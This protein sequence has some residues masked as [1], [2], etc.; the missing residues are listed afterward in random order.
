VNVPTT[1]RFDV[2]FTQSLRQ[3]TQLA[4]GTVDR[5]LERHLTD[6]GNDN[7]IHDLV[8]LYRRLACELPDDVRTSLRSAF[9]DEAPDSP[10]RAALQVILDNVELCRNESRPLCQD[11]GIPVFYCALPEQ[12][13]QTAF[14]DTI[15]EATRL[16]VIQVPLRP[17]AV[18]T[19]SGRN[20]GDG[21]GPGIPIIH[22]DEAPDDR[23]VIDCMLKGG[24][25]ENVASTAKLPDPALIA[26][27]D[28]DGVRRCV[29]DA[30]W[31]AQGRACPPY[32]VGVGIAGAAD[33]AAALAKRQLLRR[34]DQTNPVPQLD[35]LESQL[36][37][38]C[39]DL[40]IGPAGMGGRNTVLGVK[41]AALHRHPAS[42]FVAV[43]F[44]CWACRRGRMTW[45]AGRTHYEL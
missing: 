12:R 23:L 2:D 5:F 31:R 35:S 39:N 13:S 16:A 10:A 40:G 3:N 1:S 14:R 32:V 18:D 44:A 11:T 43:S 26:G 45:Q 37:T 4:V 24:G 9:D 20:T 36:L 29:L 42:F 34:L 15:A 22:F 41:I 6:M 33:A 21:V 28:L 27:R 30:V 8:E 25:C 19:L 38:Q 17:N 7:L